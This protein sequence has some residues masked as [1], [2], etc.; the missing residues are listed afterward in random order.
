MTRS[1][2]PVEPHP[3]RSR[4]N[5]P[6]SERRRP[7]QG[8]SAAAERGFT[9]V[10]LVAVVIIIGIFAVLAIPQVTK[11][12]IDRRTHETAERIALI[13]QQAR[14]RALGQGTAVLVR[15]TM[16]TKSGAFETREAMMGTS[17]GTACAMAPTSSCGVDWNNVAN[18]QFRVLELLDLGTEYG[19]GGP[20]PP[21]VFAELTF[22]AGTNAAP[23]DICFK[24]SGQTFWRQTTT[25]TFQP[26]TAVPDFHVYRSQS[27][28]GG[29]ESTSAP[30]GLVRHVLVPPIGVA[31]L[32][33]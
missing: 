18:G 14:F 24:P 11:Q 3:S 23:L 29:D 8:P 19:I 7:K 32:Q 1:T 17:A 4:P 13:Y 2:E 33:L 5:R 10:E 15:Y 30:F 6:D 25:G 12:L 27:G 9:L 31:R 22:S 21:P 20:N 16:G 28:S 26:L